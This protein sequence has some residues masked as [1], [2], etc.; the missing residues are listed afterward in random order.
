MR[1]HNV[2]QR[3]V[4]GSPND[5]APLLATLG[6]PND[7]LYPPLWEPM[8]FDGP[9]AVGASGTHGTISAYAPGHLME[10]TFPNGMGITGTHTFTVA[11]SGARHSLVRHEVDADATAKAWLIWHT[12]IRPSHDAVLE[13][14][15]DR[16]QT[17]LSEPPARPFAPSVYARLLRWFERPRGIVRRTSD[18]V[19]II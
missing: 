17:A 13:S 2:H 18:E 12:L 7:V 6:Q 10:I 19:E 9:I 3:V 14:L 8:Q 11:S 5:I 15:L 16:L 4:P 1:I